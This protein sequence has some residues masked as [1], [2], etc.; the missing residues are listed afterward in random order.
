MIDLFEAILKLTTSDEVRRFLMDLCTPQEIKAMKERWEVCQRLDSGKWSYREI[1]EKTKVS[2]TT[3][4]R[5][6]R[7]LN[8]ESFHGYRCVLDRIGEKN[9]ED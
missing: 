8:D 6:A 2:T 9:D 4:S 5:V 1:N 3:I 7:S